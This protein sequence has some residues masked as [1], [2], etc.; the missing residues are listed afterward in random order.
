[1]LVSSYSIPCLSNSKYVILSETIKVAKK[2]IGTK[3]NN[4]NSDTHFTN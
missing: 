3:S 1:M 4:E 2:K